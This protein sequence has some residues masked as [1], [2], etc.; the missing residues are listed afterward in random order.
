MA[1]VSGITVKRGLGQPFSHPTKKRGGCRHCR[2]VIKLV[3]QKTP[4]SITPSHAFIGAVGHGQPHSLSRL[5]K[6]KLSEALP[7]PPQLWEPS[8]RP[9]PRRVPL[10]AL[11]A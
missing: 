3:S 7:Q 11:L 10:L 4:A 9:H 2:T 5:L 8:L 1:H 6:L